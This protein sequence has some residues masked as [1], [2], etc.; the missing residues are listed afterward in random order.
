MIKR[1]VDMV[2]AGTGLVVL[3]PLF[4]L[5]A[6]LVRLDGPGPLLFRQERVGRRG[7]PFLILKFRTMRPLPPAG[8]G[9]AGG[10]LVTTAG[11]ARI[12]RRGALLRRT[13][14]DELPQLFNVLAGQMSMVGPR[15][16]V[17]RYVALWSDADRR[18]VLSVRP[19]L[20][21]FASVMFR[22]EEWL[23]AAQADPEAYYCRRVLPQKLRL[24][25]FYVRKRCLRLDLWLIVQTLKGILGLPTRLSLR[26]P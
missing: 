18:L 22:Q 5:A 11:D 19:G 9:T 12:T 1:A 14:L 25:R 15:P 24:Y 26:H 23:L 17:A 7:R 20:T 4:L 13:K 2:L 8:T 16:E 6:L 3:L 21:E 10:A